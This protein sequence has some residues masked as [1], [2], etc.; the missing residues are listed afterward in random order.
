M[1]RQILYPVFFLTLVMA[2]GK[3]EIPG[4]DDEP[5]TEKPVTPGTTGD[6]EYLTV[7]EALA[8]EGGTYALVVGY[9]VGYVDGTTL[10]KAV[11]GCPEDKVNTNLL[12]AD[13]P[14]ETDQARVFPVAL[15]KG[16]AVRDELNLYDHPEYLGTCVGVEGVIEKY[17][18]IMGMKEV[19]DFYWIE[20]ED[21]DPHGG[22]GG[23][24]KN[25]E[26]E[27]SDTLRLPLKNDGQVVHGR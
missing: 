9:V 24:D 21:D 15:P 13:S 4:D 10:S 27:T 14:A 7:A 19:E 16:S 2:C 1:I 25:K 23:D 12:L 20:F 17:F 22:G 18:S 3:V 26:G 6:D 5:G 11:F 8:A